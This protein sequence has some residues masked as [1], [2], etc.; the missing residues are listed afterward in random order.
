[1]SIINNVLK[2]LE[3]R[4]SQFVPIEIASVESAIGGQARPSYS[5]G[6][7]L[8]LVLLAG[9]LA[10]W[11]FQTYQA[12]A[13][14]VSQ[15]E[16]IVDT[17]ATPAPLAAEPIK[18]ATPLNQII[19]LQISESANDMS[20]EFSLQ[21]KAISYLKERGE[22]SFVYFLKDTSSEIVAP[23]INDNQWIEQLSINA[24]DEGVEVSFHTAP[25]VL[26]ET[27]Q[28]SA[29]AVHIWAI[30]LKKPLKPRVAIKAVETPVKAAVE[31][32]S[33]ETALAVPTDSNVDSKI[34]LEAEPVEQAKTVILDIRSSTP[35]LTDSEKLQKARGLQKSRRWQQAEAM[36]MSLIGGPE[37][38]AVRQNLLS[39]YEYRQQTGKYST[40][41]QESLVRYPQQSFFRTEFARSLYSAEDYQ[42]VIVYL[43]DSKNLDALQLALLAASHQR[44]D[45]HV[46]AVEY[47]QQA[48][49]IDR[50]NAK[51]WIGLGISQ[52]HTAQLKDALRSYRI[53]ARLGNTNDR[54]DAFVEKRI[55]QLAKAIN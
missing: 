29:E 3:A 10:Y 31:P 43:Q 2:D 18:P 27:R 8:L 32:T 13:L 36:L 24:L 40:L 20:L 15:T 19:D 52:E 22:N 26:V 45:Q 55:N 25:G 38:L 5:A 37:D 34:E 33:V 28:K 7:I 14:A 21:A 11:F 42:E 17:S 54:L 4:P 46:K 39:L 48:L 23:V 16:A 35:E 6:I 50:R 44:L 53:A 41:L 12:S 1:M 30:K 49:G 9:G 47:Y 51:N